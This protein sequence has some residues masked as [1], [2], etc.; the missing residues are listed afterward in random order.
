LIRVRDDNKD[1]VADEGSAEGLVDDFPTGGHST[2][3]MKVNNEKLYLS[4]VS[5][6]NVCYEK[7]SRRAAITQCDLHGN[8]CTVFAGGLRNSVSM[9]FHSVTGH[10]MQDQAS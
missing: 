9:V 1:L 10:G 7:D 8:N 3:N 5:S 4:I 2:R 6:C